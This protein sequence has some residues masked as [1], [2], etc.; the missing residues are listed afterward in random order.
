MGP[1]SPVEPVYAEE[2]NAGNGKSSEGV[3][4]KRSSS[5]P[6]SRGSGPKVLGKNSLQKKTK[7]QLLP[8]PIVIPTT[9]TTTT[10]PSAP[11]TIQ[12]NTSVASPTS[13]MPVPLSAKSRQSPGTTDKAGKQ[14]KLQDAQRQFRQANGSAKRVGGDHKTTSPTIPIS[15]IP[16][17]Y[18]SSTKGSSQS[19]QNSDATNPINPS[20]SSS[21]SSVTKSSILSSHTPR[22]GSLPSSHIPSLSNG[23]L[24][25]PTPSQHTGK[26]LSFPSQTQNGRVHS[27]SSSSSFSSSSS[28]SS[29]SPSPLSPTPLGPGGKSIRTIHTP[30]FTSYRSHNGS[31]GKSCIPTATAAKDTT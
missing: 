15:K 7:P 29:S 21:S 8:R 5:L 9:T 10:V 28:S 31:S 16:A 6:T 11:S 17:F 4:L 2:S 22:S 30:S 12:Q 3:G 25:L 18:P 24:K 26:A 19:A 27:S 14:Q 1:Q 23:S 13:R 20:S